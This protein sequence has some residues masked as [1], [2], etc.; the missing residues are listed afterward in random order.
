MD[1]EDTLNR[2]KFLHDQVHQT[3]E[4]IEHLPA[5]MPLHVHP[6]SL[7]YDKDLLRFE[8]EYNR[9]ALAACTEGLLDA[10]QLEAEGLPAQF[11][12]RT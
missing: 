11:E 6:Q 10:T 12:Q 7:N 8:G 9:L 5:S 1:R 3:A 2:L 4:R